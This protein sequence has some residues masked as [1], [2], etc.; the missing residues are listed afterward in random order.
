M[1]AL[2]IQS[3]LTYIV[4]LRSKKV[5]P[6]R[7]LS[8]ARKRAR[9]LGIDQENGRERQEIGNNRGFTDMTNGFKLVRR[10]KFKDGEGEGGEGG[11]NVDP[12]LDPN[13]NKSD[14]EDPNKGKGGDKPS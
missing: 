1:I 2:I 5:P 9:K 12:N 8:A 13:K 3:R 4:I 14:N 6:A 10:F 7:G 11:D